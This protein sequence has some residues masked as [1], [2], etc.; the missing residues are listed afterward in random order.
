MRTLVKGIPLLLTV[1]CLAACSSLTK[2]RDDFNR[3]KIYLSEEDYLEDYRNEEAK[4]RRVAQP[5][6]ESDYIFNTVPET[7]KGVYFFDRR[8]QPK[9]PGQPSDMD[10]KR[11]KRLWTKPKRYTPD[12]YYGM[13]GE[14]SS[15]S[16]EETSYDY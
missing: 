15:S 5:L 16:S 6:V 2:E 4:D 12:E 14:S 1:S 9:V 8:R 13:Q 7:D 10:Y 3:R 11:E